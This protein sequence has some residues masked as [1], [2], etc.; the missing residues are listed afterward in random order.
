MPLRRF[1]AKRLHLLAV[2][3]LTAFAFSQILGGRFFPAELFSH[4][5]PHYAAVFALA[6]LLCSGRARLIWLAAA[7]AAALWLSL[8]W[9]RSPRPAAPAWRLLAY[10]VHLDNPDPA[11]ETAALSAERPDVL[12]LSEIDLDDARWHTLLQRYPHGCAHREN[13]PFALAVQAA[14]PLSACEIRFSGDFAY[15]RA[16]LPDGTALYALHPP[17]PVSAGLAEAR[18]RY[19]EQTAADMA[20]ESGAVVAAG[21]FNTSPFSPLMR[22]FMHRSGLKLYTPHWLPTWRP[23]G[24]SI[25][26]ALANRPLHIRALPWQHSDHRPLLVQWQRQ[27]DAP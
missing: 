2:L 9:E 13:S 23:F 17:P 22:G 16:L 4:F 1:A 5:L 15:I 26:H 25:D 24:I 7:L 10:N 21:D 3:S 6:A 11:A 18:S 14:R 12:A 8:P 20:A 27:A 19:L